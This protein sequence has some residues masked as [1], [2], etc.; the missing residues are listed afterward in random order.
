MI[1]K[2]TY[3][4]DVIFEFKDKSRHLKCILA[5]NFSSAYQSTMSFAMSL[6][7][8]VSK[9]EIKKKPG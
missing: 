7:K 3:S 5:E 9:I 4:Y 2:I 8:E 1:K 6:Q